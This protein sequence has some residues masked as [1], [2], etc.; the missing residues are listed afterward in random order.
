MKRPTILV[1]LI[2][3][4]ALAS[5][6]AALHAQTPARAQQPAVPPTTPPTL[7]QVLTGVLNNFA[8]YLSTVPNLFA[9]EHLVSSS[10]GNRGMVIASAGITASGISYSTTESIFRLKRGDTKG[11]VPELIESRQIQSVDHRPPAPDQILTGP[12]ILTGAFSYAASFLSPVLEPCYDYR[13]ET[14]QHLHGAAVLVVDYAGKKFLARSAKCPIDEQNSGRAFIDPKSMQIVRLEQTRPHHEVDF[15]SLDI[16]VSVPMQGEQ[17]TT[18]LWTW[19][20]DYAP[21]TLNGKSFWLPK[22]TSSRL[23]TGDGRTRWSFVANY[24]NYHLMGVSSTILPGYT[25]V[26]EQ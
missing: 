22:A 26:P 2:L 20:I 9:D 11:R 17:K 14:N 7:E 3:R 4:V 19:S 23:E 12:S 10:S 8:D 16:S 6:P 13:L 18:Y 5:F 21:I 25:V 15:K 1:V 24:S